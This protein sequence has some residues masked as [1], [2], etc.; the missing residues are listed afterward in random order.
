[1]INFMVKILF[2]I[3]FGISG[4]LAYYKGYLNKLLYRNTAELSEQIKT[5]RPVRRDIAKKK[6]FYG[7]ILP[8]K[9]YKICT[10]LGGGIQKL[11]VKLGSQVRKND[12][13][14]KIIK[15]NDAD[16][17]EGM[18]NRVRLLSIELN[19][20]KKKHARTEHLF[21]KKM[22]S[23]EDYE[24]SLS[25][26]SSKKEELSYA[27]SRLQRAKMGYTDNEGIASSIIRA[28]VAGTVINLLVDE[29]D[30]LDRGACIA[31]IG[32]MGHF[33]FRAQVEEW[34]VVDLKPGMTFNVKPAALKGQLFKVRLANIAPVAD[35]QNDKFLLEGTVVIPD[36][37][38]VKVRGG[39]SATAEMVVDQSPNALSIPEYLIENEGDRYFVWCL[40]SGVQ[41]KRYISL[42]LSDGLHA[43]VL[44]GLTEEDVLV[45]K[46]A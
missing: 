17:L 10:N 16:D 12:P 36:H 13:I 19:S 43:E 4:Y 6:V 11:F 25:I 15:K 31:S 39:Y 33:V 24:G 46:D 41:E 3:L 30:V 29:G 21:K 9:Q 20:F 2:V 5:V 28:N 45:S 32:D 7:K 35:P 18:K 44:E 38:K 27:T 23:R 42:G 37:E 14:A 26:L 1:M 8:R 40:N 34:D 22:C